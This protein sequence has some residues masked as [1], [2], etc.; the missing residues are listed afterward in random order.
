MLSDWAGRLCSE[1]EGNSGQTRQWTDSC[2][3]PVRTQLGCAVCGFGACAVASR[4]AKFRFSFP[5]L[6]S[7]KPPKLLS[8]SGVQFCLY[9]PWPWY[10]TL[11]TQ[12]LTKWRGPP[13]AQ[14]QVRTGS[15][16]QSPHSHGSYSPKPWRTPWVEEIR[17]WDSGE[18][19]VWKSETGV[20]SQ[21]W[22]ALGKASNFLLPPFSHTRAVQR[23]LI[24]GWLWGV[25]IQVE[26]LQKWKGGD[27]QR[28]TGPV[29][30]TLLLVTLAKRNP[31]LQCLSWV[32]SQR[33]VLLFLFGFGGSALCYS[34]PNTCC[35]RNPLFVAK[36]SKGLK[37]KTV[38]FPHLPRS[39]QKSRNKAQ[40]EAVPCPR[41]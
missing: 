19:L 17:I 38:S 39:H 21:F 15:P 14:I 11:I 34:V 33:S 32:L 31:P 41:C 5:G 28:K 24:I 27:V 16:L 4:G 18:S 20:L 40:D 9:C 29:D 6:P 2:H 3:S 13:Q 25:I 23:N 10:S 26:E 37:G 12:A 22:G 30:W 36:K 8:S 35:P 7:G 1:K